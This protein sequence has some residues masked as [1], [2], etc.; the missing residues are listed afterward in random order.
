MS[1]RANVAQLLPGRRLFF[2]IIFFLEVDVSRP[3]RCRQ[4]AGGLAT[5]QPI[6]S[7]Y[8][9]GAACLRLVLLTGG[10]DIVEPTPEPIDP[11]RA[12]GLVVLAGK[13]VSAGLAAD[14]REI[15]RDIRAGRGNRC[16]EQDQE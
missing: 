10:R 8:H 16:R 13:P 12:L 3:G 5:A 1:G 4:N 15:D 6:D 2:S 9:R 14:T 11:D 7:R